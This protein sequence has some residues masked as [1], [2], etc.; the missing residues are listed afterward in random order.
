MKALKT[1]MTVMALG[2]VVVGCEEGSSNGNQNVNQYDQVNAQRIQAEIGSYNVKI[3]CDDN[4]A[5]MN[6][7]LV[8]MTFT[9]KDNGTYT[10]EIQ[11]R[12]KYCRK[13]CLMR[14]FGTYVSTETSITFNQQQLK[15]G[16]AVVQT[17]RSNTYNRE[18]VS[19]HRQNRV[20]MIGLSDD[21][22]NNICGG[23]MQMRLIKQKRYA[24]QW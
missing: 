6:L 16:S 11:S 8:S 17:E 20:T 14:G 19:G 15:S 23:P 3:V 18:Y 12:D 1:I 22:N 10:Q 2:L 24:Q 21:G 5:T 7:P 4:R 9:L 13:D